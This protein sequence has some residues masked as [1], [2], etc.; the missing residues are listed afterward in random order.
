MAQADIDVVM[1]EQAKQADLYQRATPAQREKYPELRA[2]R[3]AKLMDLYHRASGLG[4]ID[5]YPQ[6]KAYG[7]AKMETLFDDESLQAELDAVTRQAEM[8]ATARTAVG[9]ISVD[10]L[11]EV[12]DRRKLGGSRRRKSKRRKSKRRKSHKHKKTKK[13]RRRRR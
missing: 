2:Y 11:P 5:Q 6:L 1:A 10:D 9:P 4:K 8:D 12:V 3:D 7:D 13:T